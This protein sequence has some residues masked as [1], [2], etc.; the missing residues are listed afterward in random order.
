MWLTATRSTV[1]ASNRKGT[2]FRLS[3]PD[4]E[5]HFAS[6]PVCDV[7]RLGKLGDSGSAT[8]RNILQT[9]RAREKH[10]LRPAP[11]YNTILF[12]L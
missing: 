11:F 3:I 2:I 10:T 12:S 6:C 1:A 4:F 5:R 8:A 9:V 7:R